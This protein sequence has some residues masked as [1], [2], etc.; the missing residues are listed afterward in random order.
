[1]VLTGSLVM[2]SQFVLAC[3]VVIP[4][5]ETLDLVRQLSWSSVGARHW[6]WNMPVGPE[7][8]RLVAIGKRATPALVSALAD[9]ERGVAAHLVLCEIWYDGRRESREDLIEHGFRRST[10]GLSWTVT[11][12]YPGAPPSATDS[13]RSRYARVQHSV[14]QAELQKN[15]T[16]WCGRLPNRYRGACT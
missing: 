3:S 6:G 2:V 11:I 16:E 10:L 5:K 4:D 7:A 15:L 12:D 8:D 9:P 14:D 1:M 13:E